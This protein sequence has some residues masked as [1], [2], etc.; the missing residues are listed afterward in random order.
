MRGVGQSDSS[1]ASSIINSKHEELPRDD[2]H[3]ARLSRNI[4]DMATRPGQDSSNTNNGV[5]DEEKGLH[6]TVTGVT[7]SPEL[8]EKV[9][10][11]TVFGAS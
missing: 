1:F 3:P 5:H 10:F 9:P 2:I 6:K 8:F 7:M 4:F 11:L